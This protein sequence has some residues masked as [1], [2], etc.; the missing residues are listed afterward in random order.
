M[1]GTGP[2]PNP[3]ARRRNARVGAVV[4]PAEGRKGPAPKWPLPD[5]PTMA[6]RVEA[7]QEAIDVLEE[8]DLAEGGL[9]SAESARLTRARQ[10][11][12]VAAATL[13]MVRDGEVAIWRELWRTP[14]ACEWSRL[15]WTR[16]VA[17][18]VRW[19]AMAEAGNLDAGKEAR[20]YAD[21][22]G[23]TPKA[24]RS[25][26]WTVAEDEVGERRQ[27]RKTAQSAAKKKSERHLMAV[28]GEG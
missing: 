23:L 15:G 11:L 28:D 18:Y 3:N 14:Q 7:E 22:L 2:A 10:R 25:L 17:Q 20:Q 19:K 16:E 21:R 6:A 26:M 4:L 9:S 24:M 5:N 13:K 12:A 1:A 27:T 8:K